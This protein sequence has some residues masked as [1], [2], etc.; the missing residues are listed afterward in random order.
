MVWGLDPG[1]AALEHD[2]VPPPDVPRHDQVQSR[3]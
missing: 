1:G 2:V 3:E